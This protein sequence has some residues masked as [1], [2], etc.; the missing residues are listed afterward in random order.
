MNELL[1]P[2]FLISICYIIVSF[3]QYRFIKREKF[4]AKGEIHNML[5]VFISCFIGL[6]FSN[7]LTSITDVI[8]TTPK[9]FVSEPD[10]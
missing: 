7:Q 10:F 4:D 6:F 5:I 9:V 8:K 3:I 2:S 1:I